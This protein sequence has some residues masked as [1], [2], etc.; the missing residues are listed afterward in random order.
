MSTENTCPSR[1]SREMS[2]FPLGNGLA[3][4][5]DGLGQLGLGHALLFA[6]AADEPS[7]F[8]CV[9]LDPLL[10]VN[11]SIRGGKHAIHAP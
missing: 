1:S 6:Q 8:H 7:N 10:M 9:H 3:A 4:D 11:D 2:G 5:V